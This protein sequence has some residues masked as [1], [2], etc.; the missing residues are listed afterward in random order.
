MLVLPGVRLGRHRYIQRASR[1]AP[2]R[3]VG[4]LHPPDVPPHELP[5]RVKLEDATHRLVRLVDAGIPAWFFGL[6]FYQLSL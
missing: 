1:I 3:T 4:G 6:R 2:Y 5:D